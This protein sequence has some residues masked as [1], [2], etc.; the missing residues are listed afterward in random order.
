MQ[1]DRHPFRSGHLVRV[2]EASRDTDVAMHHVQ[3]TFKRKGDDGKLVPMLLPF[4]AR[5]DV[6]RLTQT[7]W[8]KMV[9]MKD[10]SWKMSDDGYLKLWQLSGPKILDYDVIMRDEAQDLTDCMLDIVKRQMPHC[11][12]VFVGDP[13]QQIYGF[14][15]ARNALSK[16]RSFRG[17]HSI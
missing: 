8:S 12:L 11:S 2:Q 9:D 1:I 13:H 4:R 16:P 7:H 15:R 10:F 5:Q 3:R 6:F 17:L 14:R